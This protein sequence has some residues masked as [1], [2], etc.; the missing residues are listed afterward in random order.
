MMHT[1]VFLRAESDS[2][3]RLERHRVGSLSL[4]L[5][6]RALQN[7]DEVAV[8]SNAVVL[9]LQLDDEASIGGT[10]EQAEDST[11]GEN[12]GANGVIPVTR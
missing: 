1:L 8:R 5:E 4:P 2:L 3:C 12:H 6:T 11:G 9:R 10:T 7:G